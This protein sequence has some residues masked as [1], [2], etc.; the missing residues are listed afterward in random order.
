MA[1]IQV[2][3]V[4]LIP[5]D[6][7]NACWYMCGRMMYQWAVDSKNTKVIDITTVT[8][9]DNL[10][11][12]YANNNGWARETCKVLAPRLGLVALS[13][14][15]RGFAEFKKLLANGPIWA[16]GATG[17]FTGGY[18]VV[19]IAGVADTG[20]LIFDPLPMNMGQKVWRTWDKMD[21]FFALSDSTIDANL[22]VV[23]APDPSPRGVVMKKI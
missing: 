8:T 23:P 4:T 9:P 2:P 16:S 10:P 5:Q 15:K 11:Q 18:H 21:A 3:N 6:K 20:L 19:I 1:I 13:R 17:G 22:L 14:E 7:S 12:L